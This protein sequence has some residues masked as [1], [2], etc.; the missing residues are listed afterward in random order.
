MA[1]ANSIVST[2]STTY[3]VVPLYT[4]SDSITDLDQ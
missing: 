3:S 4:T 2:F 1:E